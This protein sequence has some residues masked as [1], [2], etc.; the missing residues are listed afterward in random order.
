MSYHCECCD[1]RI[2][3]KSKNKRFKSLSHKEYEKIIR[4]NYTIQNPN[5]FDV[6][7]LFNDFITN[8]KKKFE[9][10]LVRADFKLDFDNFTPQIITDFLYNILLINLKHIFYI[11]LN[12]LMTEDIIFLI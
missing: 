9:L 8:H 1:K 11:G 7:K 6:D 4:I 5:F 2:K 3:L 10:Y 12:F